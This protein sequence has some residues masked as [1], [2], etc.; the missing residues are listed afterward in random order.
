MWDGDH[1]EVY[2]T[3][4][5]FAELSVKNQTDSTLLDSNFIPT[6][7]KDDCD[8]LESSIW[9]S[10]SNSTAKSEDIDSCKSIE[11]DSVSLNELLYP[12]NAEKRNRRPLRRLKVICDDK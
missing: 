5:Y 12:K 10:L 4:D 11:L 3:L 8:T 1:H 2:E 6:S 7:T 9:A